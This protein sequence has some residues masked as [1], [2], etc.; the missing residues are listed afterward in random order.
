MLE[1][2]TRRLTYA[3]TMATIALFVALGGG[4]AY[5]A[6]TIGAGDIQRNAVRSKHIKN[7]EVRGA[8]VKESSLGQVP[9]AKKVG[10]VTVKA[11]RIA[12]PAGA[13]EAQVL[14]TGGLDVRMQCDGSS[15]VR[16][17]PTAL[18]GW[19]TMTGT[20]PVAATG[21]TLDAPTG[22]VGGLSGSGGVAVLT[23][24]GIGR[25]VVLG[26]GGRFTS[27][28]FAYYERIDG[29]GTTNDCFLRGV[30]STTN[31]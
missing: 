1:R 26:P 27:F 23:S 4:G 6:A 19:A 15:R 30:L 21:C 11:I 13:P 31:P 9:N 5:A 17:F 16:I 8:D 29:F 12:Q 18:S 20:L 22:A 3:N 14:T 10:G 7:N 2:L 25:T 28:E 24:H